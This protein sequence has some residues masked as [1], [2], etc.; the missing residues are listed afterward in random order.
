MLCE[1]CEKNKATTFLTL[2]VDDQV[3]KMHLC[4]SCAASS[5][6]NGSNPVSITDVLLGLGGNKEASVVTSRKTCPQCHM[7]F[8]DFKKTSRLGCQTCYE[9]FAGELEPLLEAMHRGKYHA[10]K[11]PSHTTESSPV[12]KQLAALRESLA[13]AVK[14]EDYEAAAR[15]RDQ[16]QANLKKSSQHQSKKTP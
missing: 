8:S 14:A 13:A 5:G 15:F 3:K 16:I 12:Q 10:G 6:L 9:A 4:E 11:T 2:M 7:R 1:M